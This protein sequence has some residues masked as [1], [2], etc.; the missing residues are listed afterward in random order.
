MIS[1]HNGFQWNTCKFSG[2]KG[3]WLPV[4]YSD[5]K[6]EVLLYLFSIILLD[7]MSDEKLEYVP[8]AL[9][10]FLELRTQCYETL[11]AF[12]DVRRVDQAVR[13]LE[14]DERLGQ[15]REESLQRRGD[16]VHRDV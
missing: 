15:V 14:R 4:H 1:K 9:R 11:V 3:G 5:R 10:H 8:V 6:T 7:E 13:Q 16:R 2:L 12:P